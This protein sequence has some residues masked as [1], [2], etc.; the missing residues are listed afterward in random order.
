MAFETVLAYIYELGVCGSLSVD[1][2]KELPPANI[3]KRFLARS[4][5]TGMR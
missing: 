5:Q 1:V 4:R 3:R 2:P